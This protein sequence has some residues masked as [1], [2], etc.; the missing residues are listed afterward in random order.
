MKEIKQ[1]CAKSFKAICCDMSPKKTEVA[2]YHNIGT[3]CKGGGFACLDRK[4]GASPFGTRDSLPSFLGKKS[5]KK[6]Y[7]EV[8]ESTQNWN[9]QVKKLED[10]YFFSFFF[11]PSLKTLGGIKWGIVNLYLSIF[12]FAPFNKRKILVPTLQL[13]WQETPMCE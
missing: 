1:I 13:S 10:L 12:F 2:T 6:I 8:K 5:K 7:L 11:F 4:C 9:Y 3:F